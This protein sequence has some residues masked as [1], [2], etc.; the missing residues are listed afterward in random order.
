MRF[1]AFLKAAETNVASNKVISVNWVMT[2]KPPIRYTVP[3]NRI[4][5]TKQQYQFIIS[6]VIIASL[7]GSIVFYLL[8]IGRSKS[9]VSLS[10]RIY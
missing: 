10:K 9:I 1:T 7:I 5:I 8:I 4:H 3:I 6:K 2:F